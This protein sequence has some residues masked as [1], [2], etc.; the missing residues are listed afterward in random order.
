MSFPVIENAIG[1]IN[2]VNRLFRTTAD[3]QPDT[4]KVWLNGLL[5][6]KDGS[7]GWAEIGGKRFQMHEA[8]HVGDTV[9]VYY[10][11]FA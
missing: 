1:S 10:M 9:R 3:Y 4:L 8:P 7:D 2:G 11:P 6:K 5:L